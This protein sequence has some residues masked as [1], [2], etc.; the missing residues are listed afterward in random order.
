M[1]Y[2]F[3]YAPTV[4]LREYRLMKT[5]DLTLSQA[6]VRYL[7]AQ[8]TEIDGERVPLFAGVWAIFGH[9]NVPALGEALAAVRDTLPT[10]RGQNE[11]GM[12][13][14][15]TAYAKQ[16]RRRRMM[17][18]TSSIGP[19][20]SNMLTGAATAMVN[21][22]PVLLLPA[23]V[24]MHRAG[25]PIL[26]ELESGTDGTCSVNDCFR[27]VSAW[28]DRLVK[29]E[30]LMTS[31][32]RAMAVLTDP[33][34]CGPVTLCLP[35]DVQAEAFAFPESFFADTIHRQPRIGAD[36][37]S[38]ATAVE[39]ITGAQRPVV[40][41]GGGVHYAGAVEVLRDWVSRRALPVVE[42]SA[43]KGALRFDDPLNAGGV[44]VVG[45][46]SANTL[47]AE[48]DLLITVGTRLADFTTGSRSL[49]GNLRTRQININVAHLDVYKH[50]ALA[51]RGDAQ[52]VLKALDAAMGSYRAPESW[53]ARLRE[54]QAAW[55]QE[56]AAATRPPPAGSNT[57]PSDAQV[58]AVI[59]ASANPDTDVLVVAA[60][61]MP[62]EGMKLWRAGHSAAYHSEY[63]YSCM[64][65]EIAGGVGVRLAHS[66]GE[67]YVVVG[68]GSYLMMN[69][70]ILTAVSLGL[71]LIIVVLDNRGFGCIN[72]LQLACG[73]ER[74]NNLL[75]DGTAIV[76]DAPRVDFAAHAASLGAAAEHV[77]GL[78]ELAAALERARSSRQ[79][80]CI[81]IDTNPHD[82]TGGGSWWQVGIPEV[83]DRDSV[84]EARCNWQER[85][86][87]EQPW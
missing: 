47:V 12:V 68:D 66:G 50:G 86:R 3:H 52:R 38:L 83:S 19:G 28:F 73:G 15:A 35:Q 5:I 78:D 17:V 23:D 55:Q 34:T 71:K 25:S 80:Q 16:M 29:P 24:F 4:V 62:A 81:V 57:R 37:T 30:Q 33:E 11:Q 8:Y 49:I 41:A 7:C 36:E 67:V 10:Y 32:P 72:R 64:G 27:P 79:T 48:A 63:G 14:A 31:L 39:W 45:T 70:D 46:S 51:V 26:Q 44:G 21:R 42:T 84:L 9:G 2:S 60:G 85:G 74:F 58:T 6:L 18:C 77:A 87:T 69:S 13:H 56:A 61:S 54:C 53:P 82:S 22:L 43:G 1:E 65:Y 76:A 40:V 75:D 59:D 20:A